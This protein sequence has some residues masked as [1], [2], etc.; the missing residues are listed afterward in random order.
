MRAVLALALVLALAAPARASTAAIDVGYECETDQP[1]DRYGGGWSWAIVNY[2]AAPG[3]AN[4]LTVASNGQA[5]IL[6]DPA[7][8]IR[9]GAHCVSIDAHTASCDAGKP[10]FSADQLTVQ[11]GDRDDT[12]TIA[13]G[14]VPTGWLEGGRGDDVLTGGPEDDALVPGPGTDRLDGGDGVD[15]LNFGAL[16]HP[17]TVDM[18]AGRSSEGDS[19]TRIEA[20]RGGDRADRLIGGPGP[21]KLYGSSGD[22][23]ILGRGG[24][25]LLSGDTGADRVDGGRGD[26]TLV[27]DNPPA[28]PI[29]LPRI[30][31][32]PDVLRGGAG[33]DTLTDVG[34]ANRMYGGPGSDRLVGGLG[35]DRLFGGPGADVLR[36][37]GDH[38]RDR[39]DCGRGRDR[40]TIDAKDAV[41]ACETLRPRGYTGRR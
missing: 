11:L 30:L 32:S 16:H 22:D 31:L 21:D 35:A 4:R 24:D 40:A 1:C 5:L 26:D 36:A 8:T 3:E 28:D 23:V 34:G 10:R 14:P 19:F 12:A 33:N 9:A 13:P 37:R 38:R 20:A 25:D 7:A 2:V 17:V 39:A 15:E 18:A 27:G 6:T 29:D 41:H